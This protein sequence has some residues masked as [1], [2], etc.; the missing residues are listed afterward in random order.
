[1]GLGMLGGGVPPTGTRGTQ[2]VIDMAWPVR[3]LS[4]AGSFWCN[5]RGGA[6]ADQNGNSTN[7]GGGGAI[8]VRP[9]KGR[10]AI[11]NRC[12]SVTVNT[13][14]RIN[15]PGIAYPTMQKT[16][17]DLTSS[18]DFNVFSYRALLAFDRLAGALLTPAANDYG[19]GLCPGGGQPYSSG[20]TTA[21]GC[22]FRFNNAGSLDYRSRIAGGGAGN[23]YTQA[24]ALPN[25]FDETQW[26]WYEIR[27]L[28]ANA[29]RNALLRLYIDAALLL[30]LDIGGGVPAQAINPYYGVSNDS[31]GMEWNLVNTCQVVNQTIYLGQYRYIAAP[32]EDAL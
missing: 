27:L 28:G 15:M 5:P 16:P 6:A 1:M 9:Y 21:P 3:L 24:I 32:S 7:V 25:G 29:Q 31:H 4:G 19:F 22:A 18:D 10:T 17:V 26:H 2:R 12:T 30:E 20:Q 13:G 8:D 14:P 11:R 23:D